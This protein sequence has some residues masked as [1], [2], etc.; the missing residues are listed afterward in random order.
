MD[1]ETRKREEERPLREAGEGEAEGFE[2]AEAA[3]IE[4]AEHGDEVDPTQDAYGMEAESA[5]AAES[6]EADHVKST[7][8]RDED[9]DRSP[10]SD[11]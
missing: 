6:G 11:R 9:A 8:R 10:A 4:A 7:E 3:L 1:R 2:E 5:R